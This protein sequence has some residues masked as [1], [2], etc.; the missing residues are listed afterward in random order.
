MMRGYLKTLTLKELEKSPKTGY[1]LIKLIEEHTGRKPSFGSIYPLLENLLKC[2]CVTVKK[3]DKKKT[4]S[5]TK[6][7]KKE[8]KELLSKKNEMLTKLEEGMKL[9]ETI[10]DDK[11]SEM[12]K[13]QMQVMHMM[14]EG[15]I[16]IEEGPREMHELKQIFLKLIVEGKIKEHKKEISRILK[17][18]NS[19]LRKLK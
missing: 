14:K 17:R 5:I 19:E 10:S 16:S 11:H 1:A 2:D 3:E 4:Y 18:T 12:I 15:K 6:Q 13:L 8:L 7:G 9:F